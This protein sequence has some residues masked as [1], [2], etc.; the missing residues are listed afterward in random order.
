M[1]H[2]AAG[3]HHSACRL[4]APAGGGLAELPENRDRRQSSGFLK[5][6]LVRISTSRSVVLDRKTDLDFVKSKQ[7][8]HVSFVTLDS[9]E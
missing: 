2:V 1:E 5:L 9:S 8:F 6:F 7:Q 3:P 4:S